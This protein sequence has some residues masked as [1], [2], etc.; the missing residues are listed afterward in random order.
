MN[1]FVFVLAP[2]Y[3]GST[4]LYRLIETSPHVSALP[5]EGQFLQEVKEVMRAA[6]WDSA[7]EMPWHEIRTAWEVYWD[8]S[9]PI[10]LEKSP[11]NMIRAKAIEAAF[12]PAYFIVMMRSPYAH[13]EGL[14]RRAHVPPM[15]LPKKAGRAQI[16]ARA[17]ELWLS[18]AETQRET[19]KKGRNV[20]WLTYEQLTQ[21][22]DAAAA[23]IKEFLPDLGQLDTAARFGVH[24]VEGTKARE[25][26]D[27]NEAKQRLLTKADFEIIND[28]L[29]GH[30]DLLSFF[31]YTLLRPSEDQ[32]WVALRSRA[33]NQL[34]RTWSNIIKNLP[35]HGKTKS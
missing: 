16:V 35:G 18:F 21:N 4:V 34:K 20:V 17:A 23:R 8:K 5:G 13:I 7:L 19:I 9:K 14:T 26:E 11:P 31:G 33:V 6:P 1:K 29:G 28:V 12:D 15:N 27:M 32:N 24:S 3:S 10:L 25:L 2:P 22:P 30:S